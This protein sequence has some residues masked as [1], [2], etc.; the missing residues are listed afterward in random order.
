VNAIHGEQVE[1]GLILAGDTGWEPHEVLLQG[2][3]AWLPRMCWVGELIWS[4]R[5]IIIDLCHTVCHFCRSLWWKVIGTF[6]N[7]Y[8]TKENISPLN[9]TKLLVPVF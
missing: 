6:L 2:Q 7:M 3:G 9:I 5:S 1:R 4:S 8:N